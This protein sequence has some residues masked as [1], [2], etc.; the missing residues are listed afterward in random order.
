MATRNEFLRSRPAQRTRN[1]LFD[2][3]NLI[4]PVFVVVTGFILF[5]QTFAKLVGY[6]PVYTDA[7]VWV[8]RDKFL[9]IKAGYPFYNPGII[10]ITITSKPFDKTINAVLF[11]SL[12]PLLV[13]V[14]IAVLLFFVVSAIRGY[15]LNK[16]DNLYGSARWGTERDLRK[17]GLTQK[18]GI[19]LAQ[20]QKADLRSKINPKNASVSLILK[21][22]APL[23]CH[24][25]GTNTLMIAPTRSG[26]GVGSI[27]P[28]CLNYP[29]SMIIFDPKGE[30]FFTTA[31]F[32]QQFS[33]IL[34]FS[35]ISRD[36][37]C[38]NPMEEVELN[39]QAFADIGLILGNMFE[40]PKSGHDGASAFF[41]NM[42]QDLLTG[43]IFHILASGIYQKEQKNLN[44]V[45]GILSQAAARNTDE[46]GEETGAGDAL[47]HEMMDSR[48]YDK[49]GKE[50]DYI[51]RIISN[52]AARCLGQ[53]TKVR[54][55]T[56]TTVFSKMRLFED[57]N[58]AFVTGHSDF[59]LQDFYDSEAPISLY[60]TV[61]FS[62]ITRIAPVFKMLINF[63]LNKFSRG[64]A[65]YGEL[66]LK[67]RI[68]FLLDEFPVLGAFPFLS[69]TLGILAG[70]GIN[71][72]IVVQA[73][74]QIVDLYGQHHTF[75]DNCKTVCVYAPGKIEDAKIFTEMIGKESVVKES[76]SA[77]GSRYA[78][79]FNN[80]NA[81]SQE[82]AREL[83]NPDELM[84]LPPT[85]A[86]ILNQGM[87]AYIAK[88]VV[89]YMDKRFKDKAYS[90]KA[91]KRHKRFG[92]FP[93]PFIIEIGEKT[94]GFIP[95]ATRK[96]LELELLGLPSAQKKD[97]E[98]GVP[99]MKEAIT[100]QP[101]L[102]DE[103]PQ[104]EFNP[105]DFLES[106]NS[107]AD[108][109][110]PIQSDIKD[111]EPPPIV[112]PFNIYSFS[113]EGKNV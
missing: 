12:F 2:L 59:R 104:T 16:G 77:S 98:T 56:F 86:L 68:L 48:H 31:G 54:S 27:I 51:H 96:E 3:S 83:M 85:E 58:I 108:F 15:G 42:A 93:I 33:R 6:N 101:S 95:P 18:T 14:G 72:Y 10:A 97:V 71:F 105:I 109:A 36:T 67:N 41:D 102:P 1:V 11:Q 5:A 35:P 49:D 110:A 37:V 30:L 45:L 50:S 87:P 111:S 53:H 43:L 65:T 63:I 88:K 9:F 29:G 91:I 76:L 57:P 112:I 75:L 24:A 94:T 100:G 22:S 4:I 82:V 106:Y 47:L 80:L 20:F 99:I 44:G 23:V 64:E 38:F 34:K 26:K 17:F 81:S 40:E 19:V 39:E 79:A 46:E 61:P 103:E 25:G 21:K 89:Y 13:C 70:Y 92:P 113:K 60:L 62:D 90:R 66:K 73:L 74:N 55:D 84:K 32:R 69:K 7:P 28:T 107:I 8:T 52:A 78:V